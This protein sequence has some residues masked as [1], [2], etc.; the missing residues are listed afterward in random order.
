MRLYASAILAGAG[1][2]STAS[3]VLSYVDQIKLAPL[4]MVFAAGLFVMVSWLRHGHPPGMLLSKKILAIAV[5]NIAI[6][7]LY[8]VVLS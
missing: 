5:L 8:V 7:V 1:A 4:C 2:G 6:A 3:I